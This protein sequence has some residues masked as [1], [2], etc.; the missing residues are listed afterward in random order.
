M[1]KLSDFSVNIKNSM[2]EANKSLSNDWDD[3]VNESFYG[4]FD[5]LNNFHKRLEELLVEIENS[6]R[7]IRDLDLSGIKSRVDSLGGGE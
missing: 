4:F 3:P 6:A 7:T 2:G 5:D 1:G